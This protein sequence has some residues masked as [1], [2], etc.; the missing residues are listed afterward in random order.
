M[1]CHVPEGIHRTAATMTSLP[2][3]TGSCDGAYATESLEHAVDIPAAIAEL[4]RIVK[5]GG[6]IV[7]VDKN[8]EAWGRPGDSR[9]GTLVRPQR[10]GTSALPAL[11]RGIQPSDFLLGRRRARWAVPGMACCEVVSC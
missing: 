3:A 9:M 4:T 11:P 7:I 8:K 5:P 6:R 1:L 10:A 2:L